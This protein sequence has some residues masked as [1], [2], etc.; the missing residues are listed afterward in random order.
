MFGI[1]S[2]PWHGADKAGAIALNAR[3]TKGKTMFGV[4]K[5]VA[6]FSDQLNL[7]FLVII[8]QERGKD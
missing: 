1:N 6:N 7:R 2:A 8:D 3:I 5:A 4:C